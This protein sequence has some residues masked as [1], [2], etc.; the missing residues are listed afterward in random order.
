MIQPERKKLEISEGQPWFTWILENYTEFA[1]GKQT[2]TGRLIHAA[3]YGGSLGAMTQ[4]I[5]I[6]DEWTLKPFMLGD[7]KAGLSK[8]TAVIAVPSLPAKVISVPYRTSA[9]IARQLKVEE[10]SNLVSKI[11]L[12]SK[13]KLGSKLDPSA[14]EV[15]GDL[16]GHTVLIVDDVFKS[17]NT[18]ESLAIQLRAANADVIG[19]CLAKAVHG[20]K[21]N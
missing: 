9:A 2:P 16:T 19:F 1:T 18:L 13:A 11:R 10:A 7:R 4:L 12:T 21:V 15:E 8:V 6:V 14:Y 17:G 20:I 5:S 3:K